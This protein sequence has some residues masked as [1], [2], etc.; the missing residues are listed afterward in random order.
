[1]LHNDSHILIHVLQVTTVRNFI[2]LDREGRYSVWG[3][4][5]TLQ[6]QLLWPFMCHTHMPYTEVAGK[7]GKSYSTY[8]V[9]VLIAMLAYKAL[10]RMYQEVQ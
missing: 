8:F 4:H 5:T 7:E 1:M 6:H 3:R 10:I 9:N 2:L